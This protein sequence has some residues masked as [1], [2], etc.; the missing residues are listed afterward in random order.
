MMDPDRVTK[1]K[2]TIT[3]NQFTDSSGFEVTLLEIF[4]IISP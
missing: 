4:G 3:V 1:M 2:K